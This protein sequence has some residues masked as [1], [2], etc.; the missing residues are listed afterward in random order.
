MSSIS[1][2]PIT[3]LSGVRSS[4]DM[5]ARNCAFIRL[6]RSSSPIL[7]ASSRLVSSVER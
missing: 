6:A 1:E 7:T 4:C 2:N 5:L 3:E